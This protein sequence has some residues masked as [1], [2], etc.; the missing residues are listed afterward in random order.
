MKTGMAAELTKE[1]KEAIVEVLKQRG[2]VLPC[3]RC[4][5]GEFTLLPGYLNHSVQTELTGMIIGGPSV[6]T[7]VVACSRC[8]FLSQ[9]ALGV[10]GLMPS[11]P[12]EEETPG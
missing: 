6:P 1:Q 3:P 9:H 12:A 11:S 5:N 7:A 4:G 8:G 10:L 2:S